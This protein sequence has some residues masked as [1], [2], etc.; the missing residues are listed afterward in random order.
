LR[1]CTVEDA[2]LNFAPVLVGAVIASMF[3][4]PHLRLPIFIC[5]HLG[6]PV[7]TWPHET[8]WPSAVGRLTGA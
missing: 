8:E 4:I 6:F 2:I 1:I 3:G 5:V 7:E